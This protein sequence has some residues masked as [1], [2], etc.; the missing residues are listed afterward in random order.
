[1]DDVASPC[2]FCTASETVQLGSADDGTAVF[3]CMA[4]DEEFEV[5]PEGRQLT[6]KSR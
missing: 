2:P 3:L 4:C 6:P 1:V 5:P